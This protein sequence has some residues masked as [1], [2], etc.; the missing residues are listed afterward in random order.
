MTKQNYF[1]DNTEGLTFSFSSAFIDISGQNGEYTIV[2]YDEK[3]HIAVNVSASKLLDL[4]DFIYKYLE[5]N[6]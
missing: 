4:T 3:S 6:K 5:N 1:L 2:V